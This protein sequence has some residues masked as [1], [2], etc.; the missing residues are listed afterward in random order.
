MA[1]QNLFMF[2]VPWNMRFP[3]SVLG[4]AGLRD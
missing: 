3:P 4:L 1:T 2:I